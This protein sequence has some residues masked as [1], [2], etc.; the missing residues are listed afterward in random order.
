MRLN[1]LVLPWW[2]NF[3]LVMVALFIS[4]LIFVGESNVPMVEISR[5]TGCQVQIK[6]SNIYDK[7]VDLDKSDLIC[8]NGVIYKNFGKLV[9]AYDN[10]HGAHIIY[11]VI[12]NLD[13]GD[14]THTKFSVI[15]SSRYKH[16]DTQISIE[17]EFLVK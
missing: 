3:F 7:V 4:F 6:Y 9:S 12:R 10:D 11:M 5:S 15:T 8:P 14:T 2:V 13:N 16:T 1:K 17:P